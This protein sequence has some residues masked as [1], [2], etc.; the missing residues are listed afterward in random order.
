MAGFFRRFSEYPS[1][2]TLAEI[3]GV[4]AIDGVEPGEVSGVGAGVACVI[5]EFA[6]VTYGVAISAN[7]VITTSPNPVEITSPVDF[8][9]KL[10]GFDETLGEFGGDG[11]NGWLECKNKRFARLVAVPINNAAAQ[12]GRLWRELATCKS[13]TDPSPVVEITG[14]SVPAGYE[15]KSSSNRVRLAQRVTFKG[16]QDYLRGTDGAITNAGGVAAFQAFTSAGGTFT[17]IVRP[18]GKT[19]VKV[20]DILVLGVISGAGALGANANTYRVR[21]VTS[22]TVLSLEKLDGS[23]FDWTTGVS[24][25]WRIHPAD[26]ADS[27]GENALATQAGFRVPVRPLDASIATSTTCSP[28]VAPDALTSSSA[29]PLSGLKLRSHSSAG[30][31]YVA[32]THAPNTSS[33]ATL[34]ALYSTALDALLVDDLPEREV[35]LLWS[36]RKSNVIRGLLKTHT[37][38]QKVQGVGRVAHLAPSLDTVDLS[39]VVGDAAPGVGA[40]R[41]RECVMNWPGVKTFVPEAVGKTITLAD[42]TT[43]TDGIL[44]TTS[45]SW[46]VAVESIINP[47]RN[48]AEGSKTVQAVLA[49]ILGLQSGV[50]GLTIDSYKRLKARGVMAPRMDRTVGPI[51][52]SGVTTSLQSGEKEISVRRFSFWVQDSLAA[53]LAPY[54]KLPLD[55][56]LKDAIVAAHDDFFGALKSTANKSLQRI[57]DYRLDPRGGNTSALEQAGVYVVR[58]F[59]KMT[60]EADV[61]VLDSK[62]GRGD[63]TVVPVILEA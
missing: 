26:V 4:V 44:D 38:K 5:G 56:N 55:D 41:S 58:H 40:N 19:G 21:A 10:G 63:V 15:F 28:T 36:A 49:A 2:D 3:E 42:G 62:V 57:A 23:T 13:S 54:A 60:P 48:P 16:T 45:D 53:A 46:A 61:I 7:G 6:D 29:D 37:Q 33:N 24:Q 52:Q 12:G 34:E 8:V 20:G 47:E 1:I 59:V 32:A 39:T 18:D 30:F 22:D 50:S 27:G 9:A 14:A 17:T 51:F 35:T 43:T 25:P 11:G 31:V